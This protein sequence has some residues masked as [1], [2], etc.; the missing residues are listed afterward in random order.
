MS[1]VESHTRSE[2]LSPDQ[3]PYLG[4]PKPVFVTS[5]KPFRKTKA[6]TICYWI[7][8]FVAKVFQYTQQEVPAPPMLHQ[9]VYQLKTFCK[10][11]TGL[12]G[13]LLNNIITALAFQ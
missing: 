8:D 11:L 12:Q 2:T 5:R 6:G 13:Q 10:L 7:K 4:S 9:K 1:P 3:V